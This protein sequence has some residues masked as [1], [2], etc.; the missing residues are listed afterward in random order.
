MYKVEVQADS[1]GTWAGNGLTFSRNQ[2]G[3]NEM[4][5]LT[6]TPA[7][8]RDYKTAKD[9]KADFEAGKDFIVDAYGQPRQPANKESFAGEHP[10]TL[11][12]R[13][14]RLAKIAQ[15]VLK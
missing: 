10:I 11:N 7:Y 15:V 4:K 14:A 5:Y 8:G 9:V 1:T 13:Y 6:L 3:G 2:L 12:I